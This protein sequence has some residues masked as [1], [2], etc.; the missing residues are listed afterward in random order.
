MIAN[1]SW[2]KLS[3]PKAAELWHKLCLEQRT[4][5]EN[6][7]QYRYDLIAAEYNKT[8]GNDF[9]AL[10]IADQ[11][12]FFLDNI[13]DL[14]G[15]GGWH[16]LPKMKQLIIPNPKIDR[17]ALGALFNLQSLPKKPMEQFQQLVP[18]PTSQPIAPQGF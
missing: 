8:P 1:G 7:L 10:N 13:N 4:I 18:Q 6:M 16:R 17:E 11:T 5:A 2:Q 9:K 14:A 12:K 3:I 15:L